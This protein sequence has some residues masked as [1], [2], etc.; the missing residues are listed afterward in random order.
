[1]FY[2]FFKIVK[3]A[4]KS[5]FSKFRHFENCYVKNLK[6][7]QRGITL[8]QI[9]KH[10][11]FFISDKPNLRYHG[12]TDENFPKRTISFLVQGLR[13]CLT[14]PIPTLPTI[15]FALRISTLIEISA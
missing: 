7:S 11:T 10:Y 4:K 14:Y 15:F 1:M 13:P 9:E 5:F 6:G 12:Q 3:K 8:L 2:E